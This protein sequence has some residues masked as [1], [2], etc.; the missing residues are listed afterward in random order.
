M[1]APK[2]MPVNIHIFNSLQ[3][4]PRHSKIKYKT[5]ISTV[6]DDLTLGVKC[7]KNKCIYR[8]LACRIYDIYPCYAYL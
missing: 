5:N 1:Y 2:E 3:K 8:T 4:F 7:L 6:Y